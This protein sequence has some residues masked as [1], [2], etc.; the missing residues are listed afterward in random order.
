ML[1][2]YEAKYVTFALQQSEFA[3]NKIK[4][5]RIHTRNRSIKLTNMKAN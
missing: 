1:K 2:K 3:P 5:Y 4:E